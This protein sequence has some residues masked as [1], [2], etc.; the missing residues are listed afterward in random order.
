MLHGRR[1]LPVADRYLSRGTKIATLEAVNIERRGRRVLSAPDLNGQCQCLTQRYTLRMNGGMDTHLRGTSRTD[2]PE[3]QAEEGNT[4][5]P[6]HS[7]SL[8]IS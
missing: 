3:Q 4:R 8:P 1:D 2:Q 7:S 6:S 5:A